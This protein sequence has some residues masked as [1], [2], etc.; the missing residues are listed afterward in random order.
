VLTGV[1]ANAHSA[2]DTKI[3]RSW[4]VPLKSIVAANRKYFGIPVAAETSEQQTANLQSTSLQ[5]GSSVVRGFA[6]LENVE[7]PAG[8][9]PSSNRFVP[10]GAGFARLAN[11]EIISDDAKVEEGDDAYFITK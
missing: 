5:K 6:L 9:R 10:I 11:A 2:N 4:G 1:R 7:I 8:E 3:Y